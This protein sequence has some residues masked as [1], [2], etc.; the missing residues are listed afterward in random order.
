MDAADLYR[1]GQDKEALLPYLRKYGLISLNGNINP[2][3]LQ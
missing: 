1:K 2:K 3:K